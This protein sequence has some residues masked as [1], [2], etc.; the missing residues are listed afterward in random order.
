ML[1]YRYM[2]QSSTSDRIVFKKGEQ[3]QFIFDCKSRM[4]MTWTKLSKILGVNCRTLRDW[5][6]EK[7]KMSYVSANLISE[8]SGVLI[9][10]DTSIMNWSDHLKRISQKGG[11]AK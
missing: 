1:I 9:P 11:R 2:A 4:N 3:S 7:K 10:D 6:K 5:S 8:R